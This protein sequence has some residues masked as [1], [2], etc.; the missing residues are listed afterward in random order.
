MK[1]E[2]IKKVFERA[3][4][5]YNDDVCIDDIKVQELDPSLSIEDAFI[6]YMLMAN[7]CAGDDF[8]R[9]I[10]TSDGEIEKFDIE[11]GWFKEVETLRLTDKRREATVKLVRDIYEIVGGEDVDICRVEGYD[12]CPNIG[13]GNRE[14]RYMWLTD[15]DDP[16]FESNNVHASDDKGNEIDGG[17]E[18]FSWDDLTDAEKDAIPVALEKFLNAYLNDTLLPEQ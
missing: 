17:Y 14:L 4:E 8:Y 10:G 5:L 18:I 7:W 6:I 1:T 16:R 12:K 11:S 13:V 9:K 15:D 2:K 3:K